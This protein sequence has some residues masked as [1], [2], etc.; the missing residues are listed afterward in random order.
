MKFRK[1]RKQDDER[2]SV[3]AWQY[4][5]NTSRL[6]IAVAREHEFKKFHYI[7]CNR[8]LV[9]EDCSPHKNL[10]LRLRVSR[11]ARISSVKMQEDFGVMNFSS[12][13]LPSMGH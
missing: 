10:K 7:P 13:N 4:L 11:Y 12:V 5:I 9:P 2:N 1:T 8:K 3:F 6:S